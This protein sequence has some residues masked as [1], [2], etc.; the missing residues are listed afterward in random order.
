MPQPVAHVFGR[1]TPRPWLN[2]LYAY[3]ENGMRG[4]RK[5]NVVNWRAL[6]GYRDYD[7]DAVDAVFSGYGTRNL[8][9]LEDRHGAN[10]L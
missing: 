10:A 3:V 4:A 6:P 9:W 8:P 7:P 2:D 5:E 1:H